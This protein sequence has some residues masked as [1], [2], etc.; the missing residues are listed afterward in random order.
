LLY[1]GLADAEH[2][3]RVQATSGQTTAYFRNL[4]KLNSVLNDGPS[5]DGGRVAKSRGDHRHHA[6][7][8]AVIGLTDAGMVK[9]LSDAAQCAPLAGRKRFAALEGPWPNFVDSVRQEIDKIVVS[10]RVAK[11]VSGA[12]HKE[13]VYSSPKPDGGVRVRKPLAAL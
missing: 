7:D 5:R 9:R 8:A 1:G 13:T 4:W 12:L 3:Q 2:E 11:K 6:V 10:H